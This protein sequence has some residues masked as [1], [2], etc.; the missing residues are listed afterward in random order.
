MC[1]RSNPVLYVNSREADQKKLWSALFLV[2]SFL[3]SQMNC[4][5]NCNNSKE[6]SY[7]E[8]ICCK[9]SC[10]ANG[11]PEQGDSLDFESERNPLF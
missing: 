11:Y 4:Y 8:V 9:D 5:S 6:D 3:N 1:I 2:F 7:M 10:S